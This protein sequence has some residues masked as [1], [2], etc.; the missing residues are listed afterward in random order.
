ME[1]VR[2]LRYSPKEAAAALGISKSKLYEHILNGEITSH[3]VNNRRWFRPIDLETFIEN[4]AE[5]S[6]ENQK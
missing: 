2:R 1:Q 4:Q 5:K 6:Q 3:L